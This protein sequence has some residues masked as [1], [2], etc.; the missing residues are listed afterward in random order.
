MEIATTLG[1][2][3]A[4]VSEGDVVYKGAENQLKNNSGAILVLACIHS[5]STGLSQ[6]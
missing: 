4:A 5:K 3:S 2:S 6:I 1:R